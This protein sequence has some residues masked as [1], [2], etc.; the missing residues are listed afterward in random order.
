MS[1]TAFTDI[2]SVSVGL[3][4]PTA[5]DIQEIHPANIVFSYFGIDILLVHIEY[6]ALFNGLVV[7]TVA[8]GGTEHG[9]GLYQVWRTDFFMEN[10]TAGITVAR[11]LHGSSY[12]KGEMFACVTGFADIASRG[13]SHEVQPD[14]L[15]ESV[16]I[17]GSHPLKQRK[18]Q[19][20][21]EY[22]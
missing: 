15:Q 11:T 14:F 5:E 9:V 12:Q 1:K 17:V 22:R 21:V 19:Q 16:E 3:L 4:N 10:K 8:A 6:V 18:L 13:I 7:P 20:G 2:P